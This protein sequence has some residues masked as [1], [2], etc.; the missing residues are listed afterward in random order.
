MPHRE[1][2]EFVV[3]VF[4]KMFVFWLPDTNAPDIKIYGALSLLIGP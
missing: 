3:L 1:K 4:S 2:R